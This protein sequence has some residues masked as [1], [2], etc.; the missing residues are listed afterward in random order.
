MITREY[1]ACP[2]KT[3]LPNVTHA[4][5]PAKAAEDV[6]GKLK[7]KEKDVLL[8]K[9]RGG[10]RTTR[11]VVVGGKAQRAPF[12]EKYWASILRYLPARPF[13]R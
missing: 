10:R 6:H 8:V 12:D 7:L 9:A 4:T 11:W 2:A 3:G 5:S 1:I 13:V